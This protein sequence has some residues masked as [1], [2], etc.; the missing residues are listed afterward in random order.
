MKCPRLVS[1]NSH[2]R[3]CERRKAE[4]AP[5]RTIKPS[6]P[7]LHLTTANSNRIPSASHPG[8]N[9]LR[10]ATSARRSRG[11]KRVCRQGWEPRR[12]VDAP[13]VLSF[14]PFLC[15]LGTAPI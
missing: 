5:P 10:A 12:S 3:M 11:F 14:D 9:A 7:W 8:G 6:Q 13:G 1:T 15:N 2:R 4:A